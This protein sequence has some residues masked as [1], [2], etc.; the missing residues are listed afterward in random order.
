MIKAAQRGV[1]EWS[2]EITVLFAKYNRE[3]AGPT[4]N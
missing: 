2:G 3:Y 1:K 4:K